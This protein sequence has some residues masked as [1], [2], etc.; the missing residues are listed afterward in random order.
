[1]SCLI[2]IVKNYC[3]YLSFRVSRWRNEKSVLRS[4]TKDESIKQISPLRPQGT[5]VEMT[6]AQELITI[7]ITTQLI[8]PTNA[9]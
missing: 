2:P 6:T 3:A 7:G 1:M 5:S 8:E 9:G 4:T